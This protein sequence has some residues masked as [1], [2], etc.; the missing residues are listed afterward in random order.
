V[1]ALLNDIAVSIDDSAGRESVASCDRQAFT[2][3]VD[4]LVGMKKESHTTTE[5]CAII[6]PGLKS[7]GVI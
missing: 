1:R 4:L 6:L 5:V 7:Q 2:N 3:F